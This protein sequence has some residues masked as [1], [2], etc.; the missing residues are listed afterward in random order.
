MNP[1]TYKGYAA[2]IE[3]SDEDDCF[4]GHIAGI[5]DIVGFHGE[6][7]QQ[8]RDAF[9]EAVDDYLV[10][11]AKAGL[12]PKKPYSGKI[13]LRVSPELHAKAAMIAAAQGKSLNALASE[14][15]EQIASGL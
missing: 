9:R 10:T 14:A 5:S 1:M 15:L 4:V 7:V 11:C 3:Y 2:R 13:M 12:E 8:M 6:T